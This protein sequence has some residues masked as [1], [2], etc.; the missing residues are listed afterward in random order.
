MPRQPRISTSPSQHEVLDCR[1]GAATF[2]KDSTLVSS[3]TSK[4]DGRL[5]GHK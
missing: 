1:S 2:E 3:S 5:R 4:L